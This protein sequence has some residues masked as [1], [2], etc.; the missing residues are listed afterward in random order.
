MTS[1]ARASDPTGVVAVTDVK[2]L[3]N[4]AEL[5]DIVF[6]ETR[7]CRVV[8]DAPEADGSAQ[9]FSMQIMLRVESQ[10]LE[11]RC[12]AQ[13]EG[14]GG[15]YVSDASAV[16]SLSEPSD[17]DEDTVRIFAE[18]VGVM[19]VYPYIRESITQGGARL[20]LERPILP[21]LRAGDVKLGN[22]DQS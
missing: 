9:G 14:L 8:D 12:K 21:L 4:S 18:K 2:Q 17:I 7:A 22:P 10:L 1:A 11:V 16:F 13:A 15:Q 5:T 3:L 19:A 6:Y 20:G